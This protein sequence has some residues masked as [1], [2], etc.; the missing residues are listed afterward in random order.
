M[1][2]KTPS[3]R[4]ESPR[5]PRTR[6]GCGLSGVRERKVAPGGA[7]RVRSVLRKLPLR[8]DPTP[9]PNRDSMGT[10]AGLK[11]CQQMS[12]VR[13][14]RLLG[15]EEHLADLPV[16]E[17]LRNE[18]KHLDLA[19]GRLLLELSERGGKRNDLGVLPAS[20]SRRGVK[21][22]RVICVAAQDLVALDSVHGVPIGLG[23]LR[24]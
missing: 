6:A 3:A 20:A 22:L 17:T 23:R 21:T 1:V 2:G 9:E 14:D 24:L 11:L 18:L 8:E 13:L 5:L 7:E 12:H 19:R 4:S 10:G 15:E 16:D